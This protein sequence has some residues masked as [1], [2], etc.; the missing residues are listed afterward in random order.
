MQ[1]VSVS[2]ERNRV[3]GTAGEN[4]DGGGNGRAIYFEREN[5]NCDNAC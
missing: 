2:A 1:A 5:Q 4:G 3:G